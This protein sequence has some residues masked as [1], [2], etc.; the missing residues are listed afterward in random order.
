MPDE[1]RVPSHQGDTAGR[2]SEK[3]RTAVLWECD[4]MRLVVQDDDGDW[5]HIMENGFVGGICEAGVYRVD[6]AVSGAHTIG[7]H[8]RRLA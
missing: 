5:R 8:H 6:A 7:N 1:S 3:P 2:A 4:H